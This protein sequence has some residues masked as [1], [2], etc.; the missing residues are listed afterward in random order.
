MLLEGQA[1]P[2]H[3]AFV[4]DGNRRFAAQLGLKSIVGHY[5]GNKKVTS[6]YSSQ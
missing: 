2:K 6:V 3:V 4:P 5:L 1:L